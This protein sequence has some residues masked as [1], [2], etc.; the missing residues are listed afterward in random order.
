MRALRH[1]SAFFFFKK[2]LFSSF[3]FSSFQ[4]PALSFP[5]DFLTWVNMPGKCKITLFTFRAQRVCVLVL[6]IALRVRMS[7]LKFLAEDFFFVL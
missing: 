1:Y 7:L 3:V 2:S 4:F 6:E 5:D